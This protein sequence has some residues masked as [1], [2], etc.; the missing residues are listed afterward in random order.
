MAYKELIFGTAGIPI[1]CSGN[2][3]EGVRKVR[4][5]GLGCMELEF[6]RSVNLNEKS[7]EDVRKA[8]RENKIELSCHGSYF[9]NLNSKE[10]KKLEASKKRIL[11]AAR[12]AWVAGAKSLTFHAAFY[13][14]M[15]KEKVYRKVKAELKEIV[16]VLRKEKNGIWVRPELTGKESQFGDLQELIKLSKEVEQVLPCIDFA[17]LHA[18]YNGKYN[19]YKEFREVLREIEEKIGKNALKNMHIHVSGINYTEK[20]ERNHLELKESDLNYKELVKA[21]KRAGIKGL[22]VSESPNIEGDALLMQ[23]IHKRIR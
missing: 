7:A 20:G 16:K 14:G 8:A 22:V 11:D 18:R 17:H 23:R 2:T 12:V 4:E 13:Q 21:W 5:L 19:S 1:S 10:K 3:A 15:E 6:V 9:I